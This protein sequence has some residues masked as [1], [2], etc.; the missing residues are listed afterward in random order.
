MAHKRL[1]SVEDARELVQNVFFNLWEKHQQLEIRQ[2]PLYLGGMLRFAVY[3]HLANEKRRA[4][5]IRR[6]RASQEEAREER[7]D[8]DHKQL[9]DILTRFSDGLPENYR[10]V[11]IQHKMLDRP[12]DEVAEE[13]GV[14]PRTAE[15][16]VAKMMRVMRQHHK[17]LS[18]GI[19]LL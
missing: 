10:I 8:L 11:F 15:A 5:H 7:F 9:L 6:W 19:F 16:Y 3:R 14:S 12:L 17:Q 18:L 2:L 13:L 4:V 1:S